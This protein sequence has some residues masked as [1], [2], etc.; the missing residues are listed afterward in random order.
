VTTTDTAGPV[1][2]A[3]RALAFLASV[4]RWS[5]LCIL[6]FLVLLVPLGP[7]GLRLA[8]SFLARAIVYSLLCTAVTALAIEALEPRLPRRAPL[9]VL[10]ALVILIT[11]AILGTL[12]GLF[13]NLALGVASLTLL[14]DELDTAIRFNLALTLV[15]GGSAFVYESLRGRLSEKEDAL[16]ASALAEAQALTL[17]AEARVAALGAR[18]RPHFLF[19]T[20]NSVAAL[21]AEDPVRAEAMVEGLA[22][23][24]RS[25]LNG[26]SR[27]LVSLAEELALSR[28][29]LEIEKVRLGDRLLWSIDAPAP[30]ASQAV[31]L[32]SV[33]TLIENSIKYAV[34]VRR[35]PTTIRVMA[36]AEGDGV[37]IDVADDGP[38]FSGEPFPSGHGLDLL[39]ARLGVLFGAS[40]HIRVERAG[41]E[42]IIH[43]RLPR[44]IAAEARS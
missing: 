19:N 6:G 7:L 3:R 35:E 33:Q 37:L 12:L 4:L 31:P 24:L 5:L 42:T 13:V 8:G 40:G 1:F 39:R 32:L 21:I 2:R 22:T 27:P 41:A 23:L 38:G 44:Q 20:L 30:L 18:I 43:L 34:A 15:V 26:D 9:N 14:R 11:C 25:L 28:E 17:A 36:R 29:H 16:R 10:A